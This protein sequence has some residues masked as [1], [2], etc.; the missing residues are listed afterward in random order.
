MLHKFGSSTLVQTLS[1]RKNNVLTALH[2]ISLR[3]TIRRKVWF[4]SDEKN[5]ILK[6]SILR[7]HR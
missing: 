2:T 7:I 5:T 4:A 3:Q 1:I 6:N